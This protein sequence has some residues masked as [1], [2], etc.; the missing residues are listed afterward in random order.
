M[1]LPIAVVGGS[2]AGLFAARLLASHGRPVHVYEGTEALRP[3]A[4]TLIVT[5]AMRDL[6]GPS[7]EMSI[8]NEIKR[9]E[10]FANGTSASIELEQP[11]LVIERSTLI[12]SLAHEAE[13]AGAR[14]M[15]GRRFRQL[16]VNGSS[17]SL[18]FDGAQSGEPVNVRTLIGAD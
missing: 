16:D 11:D 1:T 17:L 3:A 14:L 13:A 10:L 15:F 8:V 2:A 12:R 18:S 4:R 9:F 7:G 6:L 5:S